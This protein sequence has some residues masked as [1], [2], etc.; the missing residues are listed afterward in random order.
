MKNLKE[1]ISLLTLFLVL[2]LVLAVSDIIYFPISSNKLDF[3]QRYTVDQINKDWENYEKSIPKEEAK[4][5]TYETFL[6][7]FNFLEKRFIERVFTMSP[8]D[9][10][11]KGPF[12]SKEP[13][14][15]LVSIPAQK[16]W[17]AEE[18][19]D[20]G[21]NYMPENVFT[22][23]EK[24]MQAMERDF[25]K[26]LYVDSAYRS[27][28]YQ[29]AIFFYYLGRENNYSLKENAGWVAMPGYSEHGYKNTAVDFI[30]QDGISGEGKNQVPE[31]FEELAEYKWLTR[32]A[33]KYNFYLTYPP[34]NPF[35]V[36][37]EPWHWH[38]EQKQL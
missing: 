28:G 29:A 6:N 8:K 13:V 14:E 37:Y 4:I 2:L 12:F 36:N 26:R 23:Y 11:F 20:T 22:D 7:Q 5:V 1:K 31:D 35:G 33:S 18:E 16:F 10:G 34:G 32:N 27:S 25:G 9:L 15:K 30:N 21:V 38:W 19:Y 24:M 17:V 3:V